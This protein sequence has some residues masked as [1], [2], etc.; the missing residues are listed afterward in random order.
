MDSTH[1]SWP[2]S[3]PEV[4][5]SPLAILSIFDRRTSPDLLVPG[6]Q[7]QTG[8]RKG[9][10][11]GGEVAGHSGVGAAKIGMQSEELEH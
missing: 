5:D 4:L 1:A 11:R 9:G 2:P 7:G 3:Y 8:G 6:K 10:G